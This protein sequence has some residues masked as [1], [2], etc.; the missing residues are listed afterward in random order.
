[1]R[2]RFPLLQKK[3]FEE[4]EIGR[5]YTVRRHNPY[6]EDY[7]RVTDKYDRYQE[8]WGADKDD[9]HGRRHL[10]RSDEY[11]DEVPE[12]V[13]RYFEKARRAYMIHKGDYIFFKNLT[14]ED[15]ATFYK[16]VRRTKNKLIIQRVKPHVEYRMW[17]QK[18]LAYYT[19]TDEAIGRQ[20]DYPIEYW[21]MQEYVML[22]GRYYW[23]WDGE[24]VSVNT[25]VANLKKPK[26]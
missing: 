13:N 12:E 20:V 5:N 11:D 3:S 15:E 4:L 7:V 9:I 10:S 21:G 14:N 17:E 24:P 19:P 22:A 26:I 25:M 23:K 1:M 16:V 2:R 18:R 6:K 8:V